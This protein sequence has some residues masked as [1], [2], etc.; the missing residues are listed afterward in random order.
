KGVM[1]N[2]ELMLL[3]FPRTFYFFASA[4]NTEYE[5]QPEEKVLLDLSAQLYPDHQELI[6]DS[7]K[8]LRETDPGKI[9]TTLA[10]L[11]KVVHDGNAGR[12]GAIGRF[13]FPDELSV[14][15]ALQLQVDIV[16]ASLAR[17]PALEVTPH[18]DDS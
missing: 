14:S 5:K 8:A 9:S 17:G 1:G 4:W 11:E 13:L 2:N 15:R 16:S 3:Q 12:P 6:A 18:D 10:R 7:F